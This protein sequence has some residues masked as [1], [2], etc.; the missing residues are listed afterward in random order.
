MTPP[1]FRTDLAKTF[2]F[3]L[4]SLLLLPLLAY[5]FVQHAVPELD[6]SILA[7][8]ERSIDKDVA[9]TEQDK[10]QE[11]AF[12]RANPPSSVCDSDSPTLANYREGVC[13]DYSDLWQ[14]RLAG[15]VAFWMLVAGGLTLL[16][17]LVLGAI[18]FLNRRAQYLSF[19]LGWRLLTLVSALEVIFQGALVVWLSFWVTAFFFESYYPKLIVLIAVVVAAAV[20][21]TVVNIFRRP[22]RDTHLDGELLTAA[23]APALWAR[24]RDFAAR[25]RTKAPDQV[26]AGIDANFFVIET[27]LTVAG[28][29]V[30]GRTLYVSL[31]LLGLLNREEADAVLVHELAHLRGGDTASSAALGPKLAQYDHYCELM[32]SAGATVPVFY[33]MRLYRVIFEFALKR[34]SRT[35][36]FLA[37]RTAAALVS[38]RAIVQS[39]VKLAAYA[40]Y[41]SEVENK[42]F[43]REQQHSGSLGIAQYVASGLVPYASS[44]E[45]LEAM[46]SANVPHPFDT[47][48]SLQERMANVCYRIDAQKMGS[49]AS[50]APAE[51]WMSDIQ[52]AADIEK[53]LWTD[54]EQK[55]AARHEQSL[56]YRYEPANEAEQA[57]VLKYFPPVPFE[58]KGGQRVEIT[59][60]GPILPEQT[61]VLPW[62]KIANFKYEDGFGGDVLRIEHQEKG[63]LGSKTTKVKLPGIK[64]E[65]ARFKQVLGHYWQ[66]HLYM[67][68]RRG[69]ENPLS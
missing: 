29:A 9:L 16:G 55:F 45:F 41:R 59:Y 53:R 3:P 5:L 2:L 40:N 56:A 6:A 49:I 52:G 62:S 34:E 25:L 33:L 1:S 26:V 51:S 69:N 15:K 64:K 44:A 11:K 30:Q 36:E 27:P 42:L 20:F 8:I 4:L 54:Y 37:D 12:F 14:F 43:E 7:S 18:T 13:A 68:Q 60:A 58:L 65:R 35:R 50:G 46:K 67:K 48:P 38:A 39:L 10:Q 28:Q 32:R 61:E 47:H 24:I 21:S 63:L 31:P 66:R 57:I 17:V 23:D 22:A 19:L